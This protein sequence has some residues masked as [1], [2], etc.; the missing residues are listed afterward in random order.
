MHPCPLPVIGLWLRLALG[1][2]LTTGDDLPK[3]DSPP[4]FPNSRVTAAGSVFSAL[5]PFALELEVRARTLT[6]PTAT[7]RNVLALR[8]A[9]TERRVC[10]CADL[11]S[12]WEKEPG[13]LLREV[14]SLLSPPSRRVTEWIVGWE[15][16]DGGGEVQ[17]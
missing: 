11:L 15:G 16:R 10:S 9:L 14:L 17:E 3:G 1:S 8:T 12:E 4:L 6:S 2:L 7:D 13:Y 5:K